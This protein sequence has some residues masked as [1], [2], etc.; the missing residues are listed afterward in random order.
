MKCIG[1]RR[2]R[3]SGP[4]DVST[5]YTMMWW[6]TERSPGTA[7]AAWTQRSSLKLVGTRK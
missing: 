3:T 2:R 4:F 7:S 5:T 6:T 1:R